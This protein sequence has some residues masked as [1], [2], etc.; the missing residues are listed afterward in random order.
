MKTE[1]ERETKRKKRQ[2]AVRAGEERK[3]AKKTSGNRRL[4]AQLSAIR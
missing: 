1:N 2:N 3:R 4:V